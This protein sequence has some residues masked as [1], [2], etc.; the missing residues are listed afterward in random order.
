MQL[1][2][3]FRTTKSKKNATQLKIPLRSQGWGNKSKPSTGNSAKIT[4]GKPGAPDTAKYVSVFLLP[5]T[6]ASTELKQAHV[7]FL[8]RHWM[9][10]AQVAFVVGILFPPLR[11]LMKINQIPPFCSHNSPSSAFCRARAAHIHLF[12]LTTPL[13]GRV[14]WPASRGEHQ[15]LQIIIRTLAGTSTYQITTWK[16]PAAGT[17]SALK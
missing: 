14:K 12:Q 3:A 10:Q 11:R 15:S 7:G 16:Y 8:S 9:S 13:Q 5:W 1:W 2:E 4:K 6:H 17:A